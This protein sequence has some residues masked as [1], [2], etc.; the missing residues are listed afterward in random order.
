MGAKN[1]QLKRLPTESLLENEIVREALQTT[2][3]AA[4]KRA[5]A[6]HIERTPFAGYGVNERERA[7]LSTERRSGND[8]AVI[9]SQA[10]A[11]PLSRLAREGPDTAVRNRLR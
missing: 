6:R 10:S 1:T 3:P 2:V 4:A 11:R 5:L 8:L 9:H 7:A